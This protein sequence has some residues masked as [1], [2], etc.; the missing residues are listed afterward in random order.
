MPRV[1][2]VGS[3]LK[4]RTQLFGLLAEHG[5]SVVAADD[6]PDAIARVN[7]MEAPPDLVLVDRRIAREDERELIRW[8]RS[9]SRFPKVPVVLFT[10]HGGGLEGGTSIDDLR[11]AFDATLVLAIVQAIC[12]TI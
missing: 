8:M 5:I 2:L 6:A 7:A 1:V 10:A 12:E 9:R 11:D 4:V 3:D